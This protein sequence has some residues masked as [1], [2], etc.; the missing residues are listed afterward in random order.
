MR[1]RSSYKPKG[2][3]P[4]AYKL[5]MQGAACLSVEDAAIR[6]SRVR[7]AVE[8]AS[9]GT[10]TVTQW[11]DIFDAVN[12]A[13]AWLRLRVADGLDVIEA[14]QSTVE[15][16]MDRQKDTGTKALYP[17]ELAALRDFAAD[18][19]E[20]LKGVTHQEY[21]KAQQMVENRTRRILRGELMPAGKVIDGAHLE[22]A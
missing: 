12:M 4:L 18:Y 20:I 17:H 13:E 7:L 22:V 9:K 14:M 3:N 11:R 16:V 2:V 15:T 5:A 10:A 21:F 19:A 1:K 6:A 8:D